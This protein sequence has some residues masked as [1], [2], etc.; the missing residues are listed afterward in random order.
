LSNLEVH[1]G[2]VVVDVNGHLKPILGTVIQEL[3]HHDYSVDDI[4]AM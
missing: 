1:V 3:F 2:L 4:A